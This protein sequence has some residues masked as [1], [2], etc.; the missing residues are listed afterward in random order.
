MFCV[1]EN[2]VLKTESLDGWS[3]QGKAMVEQLGNLHLTLMM[4]AYGEHSKAAHTA[5]EMFDFKHGIYW[6]DTGALEL[7]SIEWILL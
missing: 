6:D 2:F 7:Y 4:C 1:A 5:S 3:G